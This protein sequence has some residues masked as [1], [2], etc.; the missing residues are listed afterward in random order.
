MPFPRDGSNWP[1][2]DLQEVYAKMNEWAAWYSGEPSR[3]MGVY[4]NQPA[5]GLGLVP[6]WRFWGRAKAA[7]D[8]SQRALLHVPI[9][10]DLAS[11]SAALLFAESP[12]YRIREAHEADQ[13]E[14][15]P[16]VAAQ[17]PKVVQREPGAPFE[18]AEPDPAAAVA[19]EEEPK[20]K[21]ETPEQKAEARMIEILERG[22]F[23]EKLLEAADTGAGIGGVYLYPFVDKSLFDF[24]VVAVA[25]AD[26]AVPTFRHGYLTE[27]IFHRVVRE[28]NGSVWRHLE[29]HFVDGEGESRRAKIEHR[30]YK[31]SLHSLGMLLPLNG[32]EEMEGFPDDVTLP[33]KELDV[34]YVPNIR[35]NRL[36]RA[37]GEGVAD[38][39]GSE[40]LLDSI[41]EVYASWMRDIRL[42]KARI[43][44]PRDYL[45]ADPDNAQAPTFDIDQEIYT[46]LDMEPTMNSDARAMLA[47]QFTIRWQEH[48]ETSREFIERVVSNAGYTPTTVVGEAG[49]GAKTGAALR[50]TE[51]KTI[52]TQRRKA[53][54]WQR[55]LA[56]LLY[57]MNILDKEE[58]G[59]DAIDLRPTV[60]ISD[61]IIDN[62]LELAQ[63]ALA[64]KSAES[65]SIETRVRVLHPDW[66]DAEVDA[67][68]LRIE[69]DLEA[70]KPA[71]PIQ[72][73]GQGEF[74]NDE[75]DPAATDNK[76]ITLKDGVPGSKPPPPAPFAKKQ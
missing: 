63:T 66:S 74:G 42:A 52:L 8:G 62:P 9:A 68:V 49:S 24:P 36:W 64:M 28:A 19:A 47:H 69:G 46:A 6:W 58:F 56:T 32:V 13:P 10:S 75:E 16:P 30:L 45:R 50:I 25:Q 14:E 23:R 37:R 17:P 48:K 70:A 73:G 44:V 51:H 18:P 33:F 5:G 3:I 21:P 20:P 55:A 1:P 35:P 41:D 34:Q 11:V 65:A 59:S 22:G 53:G 12:R 54:H 40:S 61:A 43:I 27:V 67:E 7:S 4:A 38:I 15:V 26:M 76:P 72:L 29:R 39:Q 2:P 60:K 57:H 71:P 31:G